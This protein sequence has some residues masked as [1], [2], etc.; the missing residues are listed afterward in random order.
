VTALK[1]LETSRVTGQ[2]A[3]RYP[4]SMFCSHPECPEPTDDPHHIF[5]RSQIGNDFWF[6]QAWDEE[7]HEMFTS[8]MPHVAGLCRPHH[9]AVEE[10]RA[11]IKLEGDTFVWYD[12]DDEAEDWVKVGALDPQPAGRDKVH[13]PKRKRFTT[14]EELAKRKSVSIKLPVGVT[15]LEWRDLVAEA[16]KTELEQPDTKFDPSLGKVPVG[17]LLVAVL[18]RFTGRAA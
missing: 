12:W 13:K 15:G 2:L 11:W 14:D 7:A 9:D 17:K 5:P 1:P 16:E 18:E 6:V 10:H 4:L 3:A 8:P